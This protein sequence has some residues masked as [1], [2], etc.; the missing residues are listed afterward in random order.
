[1][2]RCDLHIHSKF[3]ARSEDWLFRRFDFPDSCT[4]P[5]DVYTQLREYG[6]DFVTIT[7]HDC[8]EGC[9]AIA[10]KPRTFISEQVTT[11]FPQDPC[12]VHV[13]V[14]GITPAQHQD[15]S[16]FRSNIFELQKYLAENRIAHAIAH[17]LYSVNG[18]L[19]ASHLE[20]LILLFKHFE[21][22][23]GLRD[24]LL[25]DLAG[26]LLRELTPAKI[27]DFANRHDL[28]PS[29]PEPWKKV[30]VGGSDDHGGK[31]FASAFTE[32][33]KAKTAT[34][35]LAHIRAGR[36]QPKG[37][38]GTPLALSHGFYNTLSSFIQGRFHE[39]L[40]PGAALLEQIFSRFME[41]RDPTQFTLREKATFV[42]QGVLSG[43]IFEL[44]KPANVSL[45]NEL[46]RYFARPEVKEKI[47]R[48]VEVVAEPE[49]RAFLLA[50]IVSEQLAF[51]FFQ[52]FVQ[53][54]TGGNL[55]EGM[56]AL[57]AIAPLLLVLSPYIYGF[58]SQAPSRKWLREIF[59]E[60]TG[61]IPENLRNTKRAWFTDTLEDV[62]GVAT[63][64]RK[65]TAAA[66]SVGADLIVVT[67]RNE[68]RITDIPIKNFKPIGE[69]ELPEYEL[70]KLS[71]PPILRMLDYIQREGFT[72]IIIS[73]PGPIGLTALAAAK[74]L[75]LQ[76]SGIYH[77]DFPQY[78]RI[79]TDDSFLE[80]VA[81]NYM[82]WFYGQLDSVFVNSEEYRRSWIARG[83]APEKLKILPRGLDTTLFS[84]EHRDPAFWQKFGEHNGAVH[85][86]YVGR[87][88]KEKD[89]DVLAQAYRQL[90]NEGLPIQL[91][92]VG[93]GPYLQALHEAMPEA[94][95]TGYLRSKELAA[96]YASADV[97]V[98]PSTT[99]TFGNVVIEAQASGVPVIVSDTGGPKELV[100]ANVNG[101]VTK[102]HDVEDLVRAIRDLVNDKRKRDQMSRQARQ[103]VIDR[104]WPGA[105]RKFWAA[106]EI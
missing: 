86:L 90:R 55:I 59:Q 81:W 23:N 2:S 31:F 78:I 72:E 16:V 57:T 42:A 95:F 80:S 4:E 84:P 75:N 89:L 98:F 83:F 19:T 44:A 15:I 96:A 66:K 10:D 56:Q 22:I 52:R 68:I 35:F 27:D 76:T 101:V 39:K 36:C 41:G 106:T 102:S 24:S 93:D 32:T 3:S 94:I 26:K 33:P 25:S 97:F 92:L 5:L 88:S 85:L 70:Q 58:H 54:M 17:P 62:N 30:L 8:I 21:G 37:R 87:I 28:A 29:H 74:M 73:T 103:A 61:T 79:L 49:R 20:R 46:S 63:T 40:G 105:F 45:W 65:M 67:S 47:A 14:W 7:D 99:D 53:Q 64:I 100:E 12:K 51:R 104:S 34:E 43:K 50:N 91:Y 6:M 18:K 9:L 60:M 11:Y 77:T 82:H 71:F 48:E 1:M 69:F 13:L 38:A